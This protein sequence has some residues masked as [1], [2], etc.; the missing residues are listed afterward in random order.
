ASSAAAAAPSRSPRSYASATG[1][2]FGAGSARAGSGAPNSPEN[3]RSRAK[4]AG[5]F[6]SSSG[7]L[8]IFV[9]A[10][11]EHDRAV[12]GEPLGDRDHRLLRGGH[13]GLAQA[14]ARLDLVAD[15]V[16]GPGRHRREERRALLLR[17]A[18]ERIDQRLVLDLAEQLAHHLRLEP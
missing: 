8:D 13:V 10:V 11:A 4:P 3:R 15:A 17:D 1:S 16:G 7:R 5:A 12:R 9:A 6:R 2:G 18:L 14:P